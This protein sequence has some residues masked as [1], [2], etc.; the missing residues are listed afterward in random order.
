MVECAS[1]DRPGEW[2]M[3][4]QILTTGVLLV[5]GLN[6]FAGQAR[7][8]YRISNSGTTVTTAVANPS[9]DQAKVLESYLFDVLAENLKSLH[10][11]RS[12]QLRPGAK[13]VEAV[14]DLEDS[15][16]Y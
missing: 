3:R 2:E 9:A 8:T 14:E 13:R 16:E 1:F 11:I 5:A 12:V 10:G 6:A 7:T 15:I 4:I